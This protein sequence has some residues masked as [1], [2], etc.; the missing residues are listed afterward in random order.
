MATLYERAQKVL[1]PAAGR[2]TRIGVLRGEG[3][4]LYSEDGK[5]YLDF[6]AGVAV[7]N[8]GHCHPRVVEAAKRQLDNLLHGGHNVVY[9]EPY[10]SLAEKLVGLT[11]GDTMVY[12]SNSG[13]EANEGCIKL[14]KYVSKRPAIISFKGAFHGRTLGTVSVTASSAAYRRRYEGLLP[15]VY[16]AEYAYCFRCPF[17]MSRGRC[18]MGCLTQFDKIFK[19]LVDPEMVAAI[20]V[21]PIQGEGGYVVP[22]EE[23]LQGL[24]NLCDSHGILLIGDEIQTGFGRT[25]KMFAFEHFGIRP[26]IISLGKAI[27]SGF[28]LSAVIGRAEWMRSWPAGAHG[29]TYGGNP[30]ACAS[31]L[32]TI[33]L[34]QGGL[35]ENA[36]EMGN[37]MRARL[38]EMQPRFPGM[39]DIR[40]L[41]LMIGV[42]FCLPDG[43]PD[44]H[45]VGKI[46]EQCSEKG[47]ILLSCG[48]YKNVV[49]FM[50]PLIVTR[51]QIDE[52]LAIFETALEGATVG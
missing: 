4:Y 51:E 49:R 13:A 21:E 8:T 47:L 20:I 43:T 23:F 3:A 6:A 36:R 19:L 38:G 52:A 12:F 45:T 18:T 2:S 44:G 10:V 28:P 40:G 46:L 29:G 14:A 37:Y 5:R 25:G 9:Y 7:A 35:I 17:G 39:V 16:F 32:A 15:S 24:R 27:A 31:A 41:G 48:V 11:G 50:A 1:T 30:V 22:P 42:E 26:D 34:L 33:E